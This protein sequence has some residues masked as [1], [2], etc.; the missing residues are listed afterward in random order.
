MN[1][2]PVEPEMLPKLV[3]EFLRV[4]SYPS[5]KVERSRLVVVF[6]PPEIGRAHV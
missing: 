3:Q 5:E 2:K 6:G 1:E 4:N